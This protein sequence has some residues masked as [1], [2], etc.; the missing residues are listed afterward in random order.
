MHRLAATLLM[1]GL[2]S[3]LVAPA[4]FA[5]QT[6][7]D[8][9][10]VTVLGGSLSQTALTV[11]DFP[12]VTLDGTAKTVTATMSDFSVTDSRGSGD[13]WNV[14]AQAT[15]FLEWDAGTGDYVTGG[16]TLPTS[17]LSMPEPT[18]AADGTTSPPPAITT[19][20][21]TIDAG[22]A[23][24][25]A[26]AAADTGMGKYD[27]TTGALTLSVPANAYAKQYR[28]DVTLDLVSGP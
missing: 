23:V 18:V 10:N 9:T 2:F 5:Q 4:A 1:M 26:S 15:Q 17:S 22:G 7:S 28:S 11:G 13:G 3:A 27:F 20:P 24:K 25:F 16:K 21:Y 6:E 19:G 14:T 8:D 12:D